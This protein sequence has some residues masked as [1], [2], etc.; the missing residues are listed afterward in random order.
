M[1]YLNQL[2]EEALRCSVTY[3]H[4]TAENRERI[5]NE[6]HEEPGDQTSDHPAIQKALH[7]FSKDK[8]ALVKAVVTS[9]IKPITRQ[10][11]VANTDIGQNPKTLENKVKLNRVQQMIKK[12]I[13]IDRPIVLRHRDADGNQHHHLLAGNTRATVVGH[14]IEAHIVDV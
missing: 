13:P 9:K 8:K 6:E 5:A 11:N 12:G 1:K 4:D 3:T 10:M 14:G 7:N 2:L